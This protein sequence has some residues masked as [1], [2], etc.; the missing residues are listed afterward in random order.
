MSERFLIGTPE[1]IATAIRERIG[2]L[3]VTDVYTWS[4]Y[5]GIADEQ[6]DRHL[7]LTFSRLAPLLR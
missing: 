4:D 6:I 2:D 1:Q 7:E 3:P 5:P